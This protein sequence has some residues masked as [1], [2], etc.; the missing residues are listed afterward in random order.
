MSTLLNDIE[1]FLTAKGMSPTAFGE[2][3]VNDRSFVFRL[4]DGRPYLSRTEEKVRR[5]MLEW[6]PDAG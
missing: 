1:T 4:R 6:T 3:A 5:F 2:K